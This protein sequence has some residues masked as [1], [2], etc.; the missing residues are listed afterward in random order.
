MPAPQQSS[1]PVYKETSGIPTPRTINGLYNARDTPGAALANLLGATSSALK[2]NQEQQDKGKSEM[3]QQQL[4]ALASVGAEQDRLKLAG[5]RSVFGTMNDPDASID[6]YQLNRGRREADIYAGQLRDDYAASGLADNDDP[7]AFQAF[8]DSQRN[9]IFNTVLKDADASFQH[10]FLTNIAS[11]FDDM[12]KAHAG[13]LDTFITSRSK[14]AM[15]SRINAKAEVDMLMNKERGA[16]GAFMDEIIGGESGGNYN[17]FHGNGNNSSIRFTDMTIQQVLDWQNSG[18]WKKYGGKSSAVGKYQFIDSTLAEVV[19]GSGIDLNTKFTPAVQDKLILYRLMTTRKLK[20]YLDGKISDQQMLDGG[21]AP[22]FASLQKTN[23]R[24]EYDGD[25]LNSASVS[26]R[27][28]IAA[29]QRFKAAYMNDPATVPGSDALVIG[30]AP[31]NVGAAVENAE[32]EFGLPKEQAAAAAANAYIK[33]LEANPEMADRDDLEDLME[34]AR[35][36]QGE[37]DRVLQTR[38]RLREENDHNATLQQRERDTAIMSSADTFIRSGDKASLEEVKRLDPA[39]H[40]KLLTLAAKPPVIEDP[41]MAERE[42][43][44]VT[45]KTDPDFK[46]KALKAYADGQITQSSY[47]KIVKQYEVTENAKEALELPGVEAFVSSLEQ[48]L[49]ASTRSQFREALAVA[50]EDLR[51]ANGGKR[52][53]ISAILAEAQ[54]LHSTLSTGSPQDVSALEAKYQ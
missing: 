32:A 6:S 2:R 43:L 46:L 45:Q 39:I 12:T 27:R 51:E 14:A 50:A 4:A 44:S 3:E 19:K 22:E 36:P 54:T 31:S 7:K 53:T 40:G 38:D 33:A 52:P 9:Q 8:V 30:G 29:L 24:G 35:L 37:R 28:T 42:F 15:E 10:G 21:L 49:P 11:S 48:T 25:G 26:A 13:H 47:A 1:I 23:G 17:A 34:N 5:G 18:Q 16:F 20:D 41:A